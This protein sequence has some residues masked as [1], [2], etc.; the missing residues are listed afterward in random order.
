MEVVH[1]ACSRKEVPGALAG[2][3]RTGGDLRNKFVRLGK[4]LDMKH[5]AILDFFV[6]SDYEPVTS[7]NPT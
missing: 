2:E 4:K 6:S 3:E 5:G 1:Q 7:W